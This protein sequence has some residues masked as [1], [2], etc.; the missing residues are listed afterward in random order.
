MRAVSDKSSERLIVFRYDKIG[1]LIVTTPLFSA[2]KNSGRVSEIT[3]ICSPSNKDVLRGMPDIDRIL[4]Y[5][6]KLSWLGKLRFAATLRRLRP[7]TAIVLSPDE[8]G[9][10]LSYLSG[11]R[12]RAGMIMSY[13][14]YAR[15]VASLL[16]SDVELV[17][18]KDFVERVNPRYH[19]SAIVL[20]L[21]AKL[22][23]HCSAD[24]GLSVPLDKRAKEWVNASF[25]GQTGHRILVHLGGSWRSCG[26]TEPELP[27]MVHRI[28]AAFPDAVLM[29]TSGPDDS[30]CLDHV[31]PLFPVTLQHEPRVRSAPERYRD[32]SL[33]SEMSFDQWSALISTAS[34]VITPDTGAVHLAS[35]HGIP[36]VVAYNKDR[37]IRMLTLFGPRNVPFRA[38]V[39]TPGNDL[40]GEIISSIRELAPTKCGLDH[41]H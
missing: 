33:I 3:L 40:I 32:A 15:I 6:P 16:L 24:I 17:N 19:Q 28:H 39:A 5:H 23:Y 29:L 8:D 34:V 21:A 27:E 36:V 11:A 37:F 31:S 20:R 22:G 26:L 12:R 14:R 41:A 9:Y 2:L 10:F 13:R 35:A 7:T 38:L 18:V 30:S 25:G 4:V 1:D